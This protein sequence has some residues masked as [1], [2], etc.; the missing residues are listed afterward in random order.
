MARCIFTWLD[1]QP[2]NPNGN[3]LK[4]KEV[5]GGGILLFV[6]LSHFSIK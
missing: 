1:P 4:Q 2:L 6:S 5:S 3:F